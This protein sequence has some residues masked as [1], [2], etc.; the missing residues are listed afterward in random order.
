MI[1]SRFEKDPALML[2][3]NL[4]ED[5]FDPIFVQSHALLHSVGAQGLEHLD[6]SMLT[7]IVADILRIYDIYDLYKD[8]L[9]GLVVMYASWVVLESLARENSI[10][11][12]ESSFETL[13]DNDR[14]AAEILAHDEAFRRSI[15]HEVIVDLNNGKKVEGV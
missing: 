3:S 2:P 8:N 12:Q 5:I 15:S 13:F 9:A 6:V 7:N 11:Y 10:V 4:P 1:D 14:L